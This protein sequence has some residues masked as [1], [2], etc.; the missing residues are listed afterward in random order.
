M[1]K[2]ITAKEFLAKARNERVFENYRVKGVV[3]LSGVFENGL[4]FLNTVFEDDFYCGDATLNGTFTCINTIFEKNFYCCEADFNC[5]DDSF[6]A[7]KETI[8]KGNFCFGKATFR[9]DFELYEVTFERNV[10]CENA[11]FMSIV[12]FFSPRFKGNFKCGN[13]YFNSMFSIRTDTIFENKFETENAKFTENL[14]FTNKVLNAK[15]M[16][17]LKKFWEEELSMNCEKKL[18]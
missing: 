15:L 3:M 2:T 13:A 9:D 14:V 16:Q 6:I 5:G 12:I 7:R 4:L 1:K 8:F 17:L 10:N 11:K 18:A